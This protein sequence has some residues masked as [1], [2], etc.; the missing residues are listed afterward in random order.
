MKTV[1]ALFR[2]LHAPD[3]KSQEAGGVV[4]VFYPAISRGDAEE[5]NTGVLPADPAPAPFPGVILM[6]GVNCDPA[7]YQWLAEALAA[8][9]HV[10]LTYSFVDEDLPGSL[11]LT[12]GLDVSRLTPETAGRAPSAT[13]LAPLLAC[14]TRLHREPGVLQGLLDPERVALGGHSAGG[15]IALFNANPNW[16]PGL[17]AAFSYGAHAEAATALGHAPGAL[18]PIPGELPLLVM[19]GTHDGVIAASRAR[20]GDS[21]HRAQ[22]PVLRTFKEGVAGGRGDAFLAVLQGAGHFAPVYP[23][24]STTARGFL[25]Q[26]PTRPGAEIR[27]DLAALL[28]A[29]LD[30]TLRGDAGARSELLQIG[31]D[32]TKLA[33]FECK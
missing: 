9:G 24:D 18:I 23:H 1:R 7:G 5:R 3:A 15:S 16:F 26:A 12:P 20:Y 25:D 11:A 19:G 32:R 33:C 22:D 4:K 17:A 29:F 31:A 6:P 13:T 28:G 21:P 27:D 14:F 8:R 2:A 10:T 30:A